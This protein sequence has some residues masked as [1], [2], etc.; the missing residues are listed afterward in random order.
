MPMSPRNKANK[1]R[2]GSLGL[3]PVVKVT[4]PSNTVTRQ[5]GGSP[6]QASLAVVATVTDDLTRNAGTLDWTSDLD[7]SVGSGLTATLEL[8][9]VGTHVITA[10]VGEGSPETQTGSAVFSVIV[11]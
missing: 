1:N 7:G 8:T 3:P 9:T 6:L 11:E 5:R 4:T 10:S 2:F